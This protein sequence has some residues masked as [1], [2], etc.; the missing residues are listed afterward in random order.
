MT[1]TE[2]TPKASIREVLLA[3]SGE[4]PVVDLDAALADDETRQ[5]AETLALVELL[6]HAASPPRRMTLRPLLAMGGA[7][8][9]AIAVVIVVVRATMPVAEPV[10][11][12]VVDQ[13][14][15]PLYESSRDVLVESLATTPL[16]PYQREVDWSVDDLAPLPASPWTTWRL[17]PL[18]ENAG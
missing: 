3:S 6:E 2:P 4:R 11:V 14:L 10:P 17:D 7:L 8:A 5:V 13:D 18:Q 16:R 1:Q 15:P 12:I 9:A